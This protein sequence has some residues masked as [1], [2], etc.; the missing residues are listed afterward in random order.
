[1]DQF[2][3][4]QDL[5]AFEQ[6]ADKMH[7][8]SGGGSASG[9]SLYE[10]AE[11]FRYTSLMDPRLEHDSCGV[12]F[13]C[14]AKAKCSHDILEKALTAL[15]RLAHRGA[16]AVDGKSSDGVGIM[17]G[18]PKK[19]LLEATGFELDAETELG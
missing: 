18:V 10:T 6:A 3:V 1:M 19:L 14:S 15:A 17:A 8:A 13:V 2:H 7:P 9:S 5:P 12:G 11:A 4:V 16:V